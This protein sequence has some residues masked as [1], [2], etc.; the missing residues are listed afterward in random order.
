LKLAIVS[1]TFIPGATVDRHLELVDLKS[2]FPVRIY[3][4][5]IGYRKPHRR[6]FQEALRRLGVSAHHSLFVGDLVK[7][8]IVGAMR[9]GMRTA[10]RCPWSN[11][12]PHRFADFTIRRIGELVEIARQL[13][14]PGG[15]LAVN[16]GAGAAR[17]P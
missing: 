7:A 1:N 9:M 12:G 5:D 13:A 6:I 11:A 2:F 16:S 14:A 3:S 8:D 10:W 4:S 15:H 17:I